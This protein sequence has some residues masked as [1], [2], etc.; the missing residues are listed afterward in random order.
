MLSS[1]PYWYNPSVHNV[2]NI[3]FLGNIHAA[4]S[5]FATKFIDY[6]AY[7][8]RDIRKEIYDSFK[9]NVLD[10]CCGTGFSTKPGSTGIDTSRS[11]LRF[12][13]LY[14]PGSNYIFGNAENYG[15]DNE[16]NTVSCMFSFHEMPQPAHEKIIINAMRVCKDEIIIVD[17]S[18]NY[19]PSSVMASG[20]PYIHKYLKTIDDTMDKY[21]FSK[22]IIIDNHVEMWKLK[23]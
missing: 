9:G 16:Y 17:I 11:M 3:G 5:P 7:N 22:E 18:S 10:I 13:N 15:N 12:S 20:E 14:N 1:V 2:G 6:K 19:T 21:G 8:G 4:V 23:I